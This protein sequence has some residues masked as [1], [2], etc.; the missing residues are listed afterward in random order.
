MIEYAVAVGSDRLAE[1]L[2]GPRHEA[3]AGVPARRV[4]EVLTEFESDAARR[5]LSRAEVLL[6]GWDTPPLPATV[7]GHA[8]RLRRV[9]HAGGAV[10]HLFP[11]GAH[12][13]AHSDTGVAN[14]IPVAEFTLAM[15]ILANND[16]FRA[17][18]LYRER[19][20]R[21]DREAEFVTAG[22]YGR[23]VGMVSASR[24][25]RAVIELLRPFPT[26]CVLVYDPFLTPQEAEELGVEKVDLPDLV[27][28]SDIVTLHAPV[29]PETVGLF[30]AELLALMRDGATLINTAR[31]AIVDAAA[32]EKELVTRRINAILD[33]TD[34]EPLPPASPL[35]DL[36]N[37]F[38]TPH[39]AGSMGTELRRMGDVVAGD[40]ARYAREAE[41][42]GAGEA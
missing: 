42:L 11:D 23:T 32:L 39:V 26:L 7:L 24:T 13:I 14:A 25:G 19:R 18:E 20:T 17:Q 38:L 5:V 16:A 35:Y 9:I 4:G 40:L 30:D 27:R 28:R 3:L 31:G 8:P 1:R 36:P 33:V 22:N 34:P 41:P 12:G 37:V 6:T 10:D 21:I 29:L 2:F 15:I